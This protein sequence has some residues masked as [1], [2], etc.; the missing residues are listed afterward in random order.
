MNNIL[1]SLNEVKLETNINKSVLTNLIK[2]SFLETLS[3][4]HRDMYDV[5]LNPDSGDLEIWKNFEIVPDGQELSE[6]EISLT[7]A[8]KTE[9]DFEI[10]EMYSEIVEISSLGRR[11]VMKFNQ[12]IKSKIKDVNNLKKVSKFDEL[13]GTII[14]VAVHII[15]R[16]K[17]ILIDSD[18]NEMVLHKNDTIKNEFLKKGSTVPVLV[19]EVKILNN[20]V[21]I[22]VSR[23]HNDFISGLFE[24]EVPYVSDGQIDIKKSVRE[25]GIKSIVLVD[26]YD[27]RIDPVGSCVGYGGN[28]IKNISRELRGESIDVIQYTKIEDLLIKRILSKVT[29]N[30]LNIVVTDEKIEIHTDEEINGIYLN[31]ISKMFDRDVEIF[32]DEDVYLTEFEDE[33]DSFIINSMIEMGFETAKSVLRNRDIIDRELEVPQSVYNIFLNEFE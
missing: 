8:R 17:F 24:R 19:E 31:L 26:T 20:K 14:D 16:D 27:D 6:F 9:D 2:E 7:E 32:N 21:F 30:L 5:I 11:F 4:D 13:K 1:E 15:R 18:G 12:S 29:K 33:I 3:K 25:P 23:T 10:G 28:I 22:K